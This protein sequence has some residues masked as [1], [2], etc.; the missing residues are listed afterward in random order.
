MDHY[1]GIAVSLAASAVCI[2]DTTGRVVWKAK[3][4]CEP[5]EIAALLTD[6]R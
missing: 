5:V 4:A 3:V 6:C 2:L 1:A